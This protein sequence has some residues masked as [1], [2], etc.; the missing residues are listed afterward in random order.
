MYTVNVKGMDVSNLRI[1]PESNRAGRCNLTNKSFPQ[2]TR[3]L[4]KALGDLTQQ[5][6]DHLFPRERPRPLTIILAETN[7]DTQKP[8]E[9]KAKPPEFTPSVYQ[10]AI[11]ETL[12]NEEDNILVRALAGSGKTST[13]VWLMFQMKA[14]NKLPDRTIYMAFNRNIKD[15]LQSKLAGSG[16]P[17]KTTHGFCLGEIL[18]PDGSAT[19]MK[20]NQK[21]EHLFLAGLC[22]VINAP[23]DID[24]RKKAKGT[25]L[26]ELRFPI[27]ELVGYI[28]NWA[29]CPKFN[30][31]D[32]A[33]SESQWDEID[34]LIDTYGVSH[35]EDDRAI[36]VKWAMFIVAAGIPQPGDQPNQLDFDDML[37]LPLVLDLPVPRYDLVLTDES[38]DFNRAQCLLLKK[39]VANGA[40]LVVVA[41]ER[42]S[43]YAFRGSNTQSVNEIQKMM[44]GTPLGCRV[45]DL[46][47]NYRCC[48]SII[49]WAQTW[50]PQLQGHKSE[51]GLVTSDHSYRDMIEEIN[52][53][54]GTSQAILCRTNVPL[55][56][57]A[58][59]L[60][61][62]RKRIHIL[63]RD[64]FATPLLSLLDELCRE[65][66]SP[67]HCRYISDTKDEQ[68]EPVDGLMTLISEHLRLMRA[69]WNKDEHKRKLEI[70]EN[71]SECLTIICENV[72]DNNT[73]SVKQEI[74]NLFADAPAPGVI[75]LAT[76]HGSKGLEWDH[77]FIIRPDLL[78][79]PMAKEF[80]DDGEITEDF[81]QELNACYIGATRARSMLVYIP[82]YPFGKGVGNIRF[83]P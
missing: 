37:Y 64:T 12:A 55:V 79:H 47:V 14:A 41:D 66:S 35:K 51:E 44:E 13:L 32:W 63:G 81:Q 54:P 33:F 42:Q 67:L 36:I 5:E 7:V 78:P 16:V 30:G 18:K 77:V 60:I 50:V 70:L 71:N 4:Y 40:R 80:D 2:G 21:S 15:E 19:I 26:Y 8:Q 72:R 9:F 29:I 74:N 38:Q 27:Y 56:L 11:L 25:Q 52:N 45:M 58:Y 24:G 23:F 31:E 17:A 62:V 83:L 61:K 59:Q 3:I 34:A 65:P 76:I 82:D 43:I 10:S 22:D 1:I 28:K 75:N 39:L 68:G 46:P 48:R 6:K 49:S 69:K 53:D 73:S 20:G 57:T